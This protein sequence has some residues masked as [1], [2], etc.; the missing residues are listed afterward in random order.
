MRHERRVELAFE[1]LRLADIYRWGEFSAMQQRM[2][3]DRANGYGVLNHQNP[4][5]PQDNVWPI[6]QGEI[7]TNDALVQHDEWK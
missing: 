7:D 6:P 4:R 2:Q 3:A 5:G 1:D